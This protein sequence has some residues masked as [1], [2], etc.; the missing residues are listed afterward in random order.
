[1]PSIRNFSGFAV[2]ALV[3]AQQVLSSVRSPVNRASAFDLSNSATCTD[4]QLSCHNASA[5]SNLCCFNAPGGAL[6]QTQY[7]RWSPSF[8]PY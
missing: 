1:M 2:S 5:I 4:P 7:A 8:L 6:L 3:A